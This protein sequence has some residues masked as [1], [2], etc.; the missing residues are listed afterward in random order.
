MIQTCDGFR[1]PIPSFSEVLVTHHAP[2]CTFRLFQNLFT[3]SH[4]QQSASIA[5]VFVETLIVECRNYSLSCSRSRNN[6]IAPNIVLLT[7][8]LQSVKYLFLMRKH[9]ITIKHLKLLLRIFGI[10]LSLQLSVEFLNPSNSEILKIF[11][12]PI[13]IKCSKS[14]FDDM[15]IFYIRHP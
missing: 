1:L 8:H 4:K 13:H 11:T 2:E 12:V 14:R 3:M 7:F 6:Q 9:L 10:T 15:R 5:V